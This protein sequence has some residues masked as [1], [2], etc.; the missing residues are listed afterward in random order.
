GRLGGLVLATGDAFANFPPKPFRPLIAAARAGTLTPLLA[1]LTARP[2]RS[3]P[4]AYGWLTYGELPPD[5][6]APVVPASLSNVGLRRDLRRPTGGLGDA[7]VLH[8]IASGLAGFPTRA[9]LPW[10]ADG[11]VVPV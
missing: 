2:A 6:N 5:L 9:L 11:K 1:M 8:Q 3:L 4:P 10:A 7:D